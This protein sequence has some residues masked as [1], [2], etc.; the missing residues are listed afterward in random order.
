MKKRDT[1]ITCAIIFVILLLCGGY[2]ASQMQV[3][4]EAYARKYLS[5]NKERLLSLLPENE[6]GILRHEFDPNHLEGCTTL[7][8]CPDGAI[9]ALFTNWLP[10]SSIPAS[11]DDIPESGLHVEGL[12]MGGKGFLDCVRIEED[13]YFVDAYLPT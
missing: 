6:D 3:P 4:N 8:Y 7:F 2:V 12:G 13:W 10:E 9:P 11:M 1:L 5:K